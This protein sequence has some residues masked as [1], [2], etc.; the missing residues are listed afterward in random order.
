MGLYQSLKNDPA[1]DT[2]RIY[3]AG[4]SAETPYVSKFIEEHPGPWRGVALLNPAGLPDF[5]KMPLGQTRPRILIDDSSCGNS[6]ERL[7]SFQQEALNHG[8]MVDIA[9]HPDE[10]H[11][12]MG[13]DARLERTR[14]MMHFIFEE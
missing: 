1:I 14:T 3:L 10:G 11:R 6:Q 2:S 7:K 8:V 9:I 5:S 13:N 4:S 12:I